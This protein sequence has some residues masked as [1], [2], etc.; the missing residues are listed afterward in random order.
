VTFSGDKLLGG[1]QAGIAV[2]RAAA[3]EAARK[4]PLMR[5]LR[6]DKLTIAALAATLQLYR[7]HRAGEVPAIAMLGATPEYL[8]VR[9]QQLADRVGAVAGL[10]IEVEPCTSAVGGGAMP[11][12]ELASWAVTVRAVA[13]DGPPGSVTRGRA[14]ADDGRGR[15]RSAEELD[16][17][18]RAAPVP[19][20]GRIADGR[21]WLDVRT[22]AD[23]ELDDVAA[24]LDGRPH[25]RLGAR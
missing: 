8:R 3:V 6:P 23:D 10:R 17:A 19:I 25:P 18:L 20:V 4:H 1:P 12:A 22:I 13:D 7:D 11:T 21:L 24:A 5:A 16:A 9:A 15:G 14:V 2:G